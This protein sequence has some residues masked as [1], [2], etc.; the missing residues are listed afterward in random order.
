M[1][2]KNL[3]IICIT[4]IVCIGIIVGAL[5]LVNTGAGDSSSSNNVANNVP[6]VDN[7]DSSSN[8]NGMRIINGTIYSGGYT[9]DGRIV[10][11]LYVS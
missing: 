7:D 6:S 5:V 10:C 8:D 4:A 11:T 9:N 1:E 3:I 2:T